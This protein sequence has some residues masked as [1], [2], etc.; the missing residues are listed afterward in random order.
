MKSKKTK[1]IKARA[2][3]HCKH[4]TEVFWKRVCNFDDKK[5]DLFRML[6]CKKFTYSWGR[7]GIDHSR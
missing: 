4:E 1:K 3:D 2:G 6:K 7:V 5:C